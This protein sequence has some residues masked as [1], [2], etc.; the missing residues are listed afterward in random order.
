MPDDDAVL[1]RLELY[2]EGRQANLAI[3]R[4]I[5][6]MTIMRREDILDELENTLQRAQ[7]LARRENEPPLADLP[8]LKDE[9]GVSI[10]MDRAYVDFRRLYAIHR[11]GA[12][13][14]TRTKTNMKYHRVYSHPVPEKTTGVGSDQSIALD[15]FYSKQD[16]PQHLRRISFCDPETVSVLCS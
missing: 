4:A 15:G 5:L 13:F 14:V 6:Q 2:F 11:A 9:P 10:S 3:F 1:K 12:F 16:Y 8:A 7:D